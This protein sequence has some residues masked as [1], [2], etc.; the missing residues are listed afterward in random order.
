MSKKVAAVPHQDIERWL[1]SVDELSKELKELQLLKT[2]T[3]QKIDKI[4]KKDEN[5]PEKD[6]DLNKP[7]KDLNKPDKSIL[8]KPE[9]DFE[10]TSDEEKEKAI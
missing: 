8:N 5:K 2:K 7:D 9:K 3:K 10:K 6:K 1:K 4:S